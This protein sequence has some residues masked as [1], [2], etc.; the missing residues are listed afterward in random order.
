MDP[1]CIGHY[2]EYSQGSYKSLYFVF[3]S[4]VECGNCLTYQNSVNQINTSTLCSYIVIAIFSCFSLLTGIES[5][6]VYPLSFTYTFIFR[7]RLSEKNVHA[8][9]PNAIW[10]MTN[11]L[12]LATLAVKPTFVAFL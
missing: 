1:P 8:T 9:I 6:S 4:L 7:E 12:F 5:E 11:T 3:L 10:D 2:R